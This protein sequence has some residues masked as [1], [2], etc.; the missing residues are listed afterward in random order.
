MQ[1]DVIGAGCDSVANAADDGF[2]VWPTR[3]G[4]G[5]LVSRHRFSRLFDV[6][7]WSEIPGELPR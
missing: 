5:N 4:V 3:Y 6:E 1:I 2:N 7:S